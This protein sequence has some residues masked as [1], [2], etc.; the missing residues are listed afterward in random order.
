MK[1]FKKILYTQYIYQNFNWNEITW[2]LPNIQ[3]NYVM[4][5]TIFVTL[6]KINWWVGFEIGCN[7]YIRIQHT[8]IQTSNTKLNCNYLLCLSWPHWNGKG[9]GALSLVTANHMEYYLIMACA[10]FSQNLKQDATV[11]CHTTITDVRPYNS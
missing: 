11:H 1:I 4:R 8:K 7:L 3:T 2:Q 9:E 6:P 5:L 10:H